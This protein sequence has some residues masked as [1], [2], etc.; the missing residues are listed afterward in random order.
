MLKPVVR[1]P[2]PAG[3]TRSANPIDA[4]IAAGCKA[5][6]VRPVGQADPRRCSRRVYLDLAGIPPTPAEQEAFLKDPSP[7]AYEAVVDRLLESEQHGVR[8]TRHWLDV[9]R[10]ADA[11]ERM[12][13]APG[14]HYWR[15]D[16]LRAQL[17]HAVRPVR[18]TCNSRAIALP[19]A[20]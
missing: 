5:K 6:S 16:D 4:F 7:T 13:A 10:Y 20:R 18:C 11:D 19:S 12:T 14:L 17:G 9:L 3:V 1:P 8:Y 15:L 2:V